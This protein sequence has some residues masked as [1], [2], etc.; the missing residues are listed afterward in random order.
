MR[1]QTLASLSILTLTAAPAASAQDRVEPAPLAVRL[2]PVEPGHAKIDAVRLDAGLGDPLIVV[3]GLPQGGAAAADP[4]S[5][6]AL[7]PLMV[8]SAQDARLHLL[9]VEPA[10]LE[11]L[12]IA[13]FAVAL[14][15]AG[16]VQ[17][18]E[19]RTARAL[20][21]ELRMLVHPPGQA[22]LPELHVE[23]VATDGIPADFG[24]VIRTWVHPIGLEL[25]LDAVSHD[26]RA[27]DPRSTDV[28]LTL[29]DS[30]GFGTA[31]ES[32]GH[33]LRAFAPL[34]QAPA[35]TIRVW[36]RRAE[37]CVFGEYVLAALLPR[38]G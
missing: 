16:R 10:A 20:A 12:P 13:V 32:I 33:E 27:A 28:Y 8:L 17:F 5:L 3:C 30:G 19:V 31:P 26:A 37:G 6:L 21:A 2:A 9:Q 1:F 14:D 34:G 35:P 24:L 11:R 38:V 4:V 18:S 23:Q 25:V 36:L 29:R 15:R 22:G 7:E